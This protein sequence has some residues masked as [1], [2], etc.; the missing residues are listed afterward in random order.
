MN[1]Q[2]I[3]KA[4]MYGNLSNVELSSVIDAIKWARARIADQKKYTLHLGD[5]VKF[6]NSRTGL[7]VHGKLKERK[8]K[9]A[10]VETAQGRWKVPFNLLEAV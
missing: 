5:E 8:I 6:K 7:W 4:I 10:I 2:E 3:N 9:N 1:V